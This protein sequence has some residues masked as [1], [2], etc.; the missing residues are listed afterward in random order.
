MSLSLER[1]FIHSSR[2]AVL[3]WVLWVLPAWALS[4]GFPDHGGAKEKGRI[5]QVWFAHRDFLEKGDWEKSKGELEKIYQWKL[6]RG[7]RNHYPYS[8]ALTRESQQ[9]ATREKSVVAELLNYAEKMAPDFSGVSNTRAQWLWSQILSSGGN[10]NDAVLAWFQGLWRSFYNLEEA[11]PQITNL[12]LWILLSFLLTV[13]IFGLSLFIRY[14]SLFTHHLKHL[15]RVE[16][17]PTFWMSLTFLILFSPFFL[18]LGWMWLVVWWILVFWVYQARTDRMVSVALLLTL[19]LLPSAIRIYSSLLSTLAAN[20]VPQILRAGTGVWNEELYQRML[21]MNRAN[22]RDLDVLQAIGLME[23]RMGKFAEAEERLREMAQSDSRSG[24][25]LNN[26]GNI[27]LVTNRLDQAVEA[28]LKA[29]RLDPYRSEAYY[30][31]GQAYL[32][33]LRMKE[34]AAEFE[35]A[36]SLS[37]QSVSYYTNISSRHPNRLV[38]DSTIDPS[39]VWRRILSPTPE[40]NQ[41]AQSLWSVLW[42]GVPQEYGEVTMGAL[43]VFLGMVH[44]GSRWLSSIRYCEKCGNLICSRCTR[45]RV[46]GTQCL[47]CL[48]AFAINPSADPE[49]VKKKRAAVARYQSWKTFFPRRISLFLPGAGHVLRGHSREGILYLFIFILFLA[50][51]VLWAGRLPN[52]MALNPALS[53]PGIFVLAVLFLLFYGLVQFRVKQIIAEGGKSHFRRA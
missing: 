17:S 51:L 21:E 3:F 36:K 26:L 28:Y 16:M 4:P 12:S 25:L 5:E 10:I 43:F 34:A 52:P 35:K 53:L 46:M 48:N 27:Y 31:L 20:E 45:S 42:G 1:K 39:H 33:K 23:K 29:T 6:D 14:H 30:N 13:G 24:S 7:I 22:P 8:L 47:Q 38:I 18:G 2:G 49:I 44:L 32:L 15:V 9:A 41:M 37:P 40:R 50:Q 11:L 19:L